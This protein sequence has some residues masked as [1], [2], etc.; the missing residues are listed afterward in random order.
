MVRLTLSPSKHPLIVGLAVIN[1][2]TASGNNTP[3]AINVAV[4]GNPGAPWRT[5]YVPGATPIGQAHEVAVGIIARAPNYG[6][7]PL[8][9][10]DDIQLELV[11]ARAPRQGRHP[12]HYGNYGGNSNAPRE[13]ARGI[14]KTYAFDEKN[15]LL[16]VE[17]DEDD[18]GQYDGDDS[19]T[20]TFVDI[21]SHFLKI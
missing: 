18:G 14:I 16:E 7:Q 15:F 4:P 5:W 8:N 3:E 21:F 13:H 6:S 20:G 9:G 19:V 11:C 17:D 10:P 12:P 2:T 1:A